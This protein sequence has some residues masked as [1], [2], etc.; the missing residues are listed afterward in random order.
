MIR[1]YHN[2]YAEFVPAIRYFQRGWATRGR[3]YPTFAEAAQ[4]NGLEPDDF[5]EV[6]Q[7]YFKA[8]R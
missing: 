8:V 5:A 6:S 3:L 4:A 1:A 7:N 2:A